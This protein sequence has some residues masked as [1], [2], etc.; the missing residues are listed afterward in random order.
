MP[1]E[2]L[3]SLKEYREE[4]CLVEVLDYWLRHHPKQPTWKDLSDALQYIDAFQATTNGVALYDLAG[5][6]GN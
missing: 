5:K 2:V 4:Q 3:D 1:H 6:F